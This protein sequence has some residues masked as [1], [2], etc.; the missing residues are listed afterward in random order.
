MRR[1]LELVLGLGIEHERVEQQ[2]VQPD[3]WRGG[4]CEAGGTVNVGMPAGAIDHL[5]PTL[6]YYATTWEIANATCVPMLTFPDKA[7]TAGVTPIG[8]VADAPTVSGGG[9]VYTFKMKP[10]IEFEN[11]Q[12]ITAR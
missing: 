8:G 9:T 1:Q 2:R 6:W 4:G 12:P 7:G 3:G 11:G 10:G 5:E